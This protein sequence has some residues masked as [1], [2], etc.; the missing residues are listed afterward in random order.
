MKNTKVEVHTANSEHVCSTC[1]ECLFSANHDICVV[2][3]LN[4]VNARTR[5]KFKSFK[6]YDWKPTGKVFI[7]VVQI[8]LWYLDFDYPKH[9][10][11]KRSQLIIFVNK[12]MGT[13]RFRND[14]FV[15]IIGYV[16]YQNGNVII[17][18]SQFCYSD[19]EVA[20]R[21]HSCFVRDLDGVDLVKGLRGT[22]LYTVV[23]LTFS[24]A[25]VLHVNWISLGHCVLRVSVWEGA[26]EVQS[27]IHIKAELIQKLRDDQKR[28][29]KVFE[30]MSGRNI[31]T[32]SRVTPSWREI[33]SLTF[34]KIGVLHAEAVPTSC[35]TQNR[36][37]IHARH[38]KTPY[39]LLHDHKIDLKYLHVFGALCYPL[40]DSKDIGKLKSK[41]DIVPIPDAITGTPS[42]TT[43]DQDAPSAKSSSRDVIPLNLHQVNQPVA[44]IE[45]IRIFLANAANKNMIAYQMDIHTVFLN[46]VLKEVVYVSQ[47]EEVVDQDHPNYVY[48]L[49]KALYGLKQAPHACNLV[50]TLMVKRTKLDEDPQGK[51]VDP[52]RY[53]G[54]VGSLM[55]LTSSRSDLVF[56]V[57][58]CPRVLPATPGIDGT[59]EKP[60][61]EE[62]KTY[63]TVLEETKKWIDADAKGVHIVFTR[64]DND[65]YSIVDAC[66]NSIEM[67]KVI[68]RLKQGESINVQDVET[69]H[70]NLGSLPHWMVKH[71]IHIT[72]EE[73]TYHK[74][75]DILKQHQNEVNDIRAERLARTTNPLALVAQQQLVYYPQPNLTHYTQ[76]SSTISQA[77]TKN[78]GKAI[79][80]S[81]PP[82][83]DSEP[84]LATDDEASSKEKEIDKLMALISMSFKKIYKPTN[85]NLRN[86]SN[87][88]NMNVD[89]TLR[90]DR[91]TRYDRQ[92]GDDT[93]DEPKDQEL[94]AHYM[95]MAKI[96]KVIPNAADNSRPIFGYLSPS[97]S[98][99]LDSSNMSYNRGEAGQD[100]QMLQQERELLASLIEQMKIEIDGSK[101]NN[102]SLESSNKALREAIMFLIMKDQ[103]KLNPTAKRLTN[104]VVEFYQTLKEEM[105]VNLKYFKSLENEVESL[106]SQ[107]ELQQTQ[108]SNKINRLLREYYYVDHINAIIGVYNNLDEYSGVACDYLEAVAKC[109]RL[110]NELSKRNENVE[111][112]LFNELSKTF[113]EL[114]KHYISIELSL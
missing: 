2:D 50:D 55:Y 48:R 114:E 71:L 96:Q 15:A 70:R 4:D 105:V 108:F 31:V 65:I 18:M 99:T 62:M 24:E 35:Y 100:D 73:S 40:N 61:E 25:G 110:E 14:H 80:N 5:A 72:Q 49:K 88:R 19:L 112:K 28:M 56:D 82:T 3:Y 33:V 36:S 42:S 109:E 104:D 54:M 12:F 85:N 9:M 53:R 76:S 41:A 21:K 63:A 57:C 34:S 94:E 60:R 67:W 17:S 7:E 113:A 87:T 107:L 1:N 68:E 69:N 84:E 92:T 97:R 27:I 26:E 59:S 20:F 52:T 39:E 23:S 79:A 6:K 89:N 77:A 101:Q 95:Y 58:M 47:P 106:Q 81:H 51:P 38:N 30:V 93:D 29:K 13:V 98:N 66:Q 45:A 43:I 37:L 74:L 8:V 10:T 83:Y 102:K 91:R 46:A 44:R 64:I 90:S 16:D 86:S 32:N 78:K 22:N 111:N 103:E 11:G 75:Y